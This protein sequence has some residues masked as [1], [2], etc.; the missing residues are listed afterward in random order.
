VCQEYVRG[1]VTGHCP[2]C[3][4]VPPSAVPAQDPPP[5][6]STLMLVHVALIAIAIIAL[7]QLL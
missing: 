3:A 2:R 7:V 1:T 6:W 4:Y 5:V